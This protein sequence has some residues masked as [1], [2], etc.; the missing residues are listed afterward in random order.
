MKALFLILIFYAFAFRGNASSSKSAVKPTDTLVVGHGSRLLYYVQNYSTS[1]NQFLI[2]L[3]ETELKT[4]LDRR[5]DYSGPLFSEVKSLNLFLSSDKANKEYNAAITIFNKDRLL[6]K[7]SKDLIK[8]N[9]LIAESLQ[10]KD[11]FLKININLLNNLIEY[12]F[13]L[14]KIGRSFKKDK[15]H[16]KP[17]IYRTTSIFIDPTTVDYQQKI[18]TSLHQLLTEANEAP[19]PYLTYKNQRLKDTL[20]VE[21]GKLFELVAEASDSD[22]SPS[23]LSFIW[24][25]YNPLGNELPIDN[26]GSKR[27]AFN[28]TWGTHQI[29]LQV[30]DGISEQFSWCTVIAKYPSQIWILYPEKGG[31]FDNSS[32]SYHFYS[33]SR[34]FNP[35]DFKALYNIRGKSH[36]ESAEKIMKNGNVIV[37]EIRVRTNVSSKDQ[38][39]FSTVK[40]NKIDEDSITNYKE[41]AIPFLE[42]DKG[43]WQVLDEVTPIKIQ[44]IG[45][46][47][48]KRDPKY[49]PYYIHTYS[50]LRTENQTQ[51]I[52]VPATRKYK[53]VV[54]D[55]Q[56][57]SSEGFEIQYHKISRLSV[58]INETFYLGLTKIV[59]KYR[60][61]I[62]FGVGLNYQL[63]P[64]VA[65]EGSV[66]LLAPISNDT[67]FRNG[68][69]APYFYKIKTNISVVNF[70]D[71]VRGL[72]SVSALYRSAFSYYPSKAI[73]MAGYHWRPALGLAAQ[74]ANSTTFNYEPANTEIFASFYPK[75]SDFGSHNLEIGVKVK[76][77]FLKNQ[78]K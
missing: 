16:I 22:S 7:T 9:R 69:A 36:E 73:L 57:I 8:D 39:T 4:M 35:N 37:P 17:Q 72:F 14:F 29:A 2:P 38:L 55:H 66:G 52:H 47:M 71:R 23:Q 60:G 3:I 25:L 56:S 21:V 70:K 33:Y 27:Q 63:A 10:N 54:N 61:L 45:I 78:K 13:V 26:V 46:E 1:N 76:F 50:L 20:Y 59:G 62:S 44:P 11:F 43:S 65:F 19:E 32:N 48:E 67:L 74:F 53:V 42:A 5:E 77:N 41:R 31:Y 68:H 18:R 28:L 75:T 58:L 30:S 34:N 12:Q 51:K 24:K 40:Y 49:I 64:V 6:Y 15:S